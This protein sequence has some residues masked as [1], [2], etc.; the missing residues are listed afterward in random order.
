MSYPSNLMLEQHRRI[1]RRTRFGPNRKDIGPRPGGSHQTVR[2]VIRGPK[3]HL[4]S[5]TARPYGQSQVALTVRFAV[6]VVPPRAGAQGQG[7]RLRG[8]GPP[9]AERG[10]TA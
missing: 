2:G 7:S 3:R 1:R 6:V 8:D 5:K 4:R 10:C 9:A